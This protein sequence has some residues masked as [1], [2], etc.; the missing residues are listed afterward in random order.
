MEYPART[1]F[2]VIAATLVIPAC[3]PGLAYSLG[4][5]AVNTGI[6]A[7]ASAERRSEGGCWTPCGEGTRCN[8]ETGY[9]ESEESVGEDPAQLASAGEPD[10]AP[11][12]DKREGARWAMEKLI[13]ICGSDDWS[14]AADLVAYRGDDPARRW[15]DV[16]DYSVPDEKQHVDDA[17]SF[18]AGLLQAPGYAGHEFVEFWRDEE[19]EGEWL[20]WVVVFDYGQ[21]TEQVVFASLAI[22]GSYA[23]GDID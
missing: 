14:G 6:A 5:A 13:G 19:S 3:N 23:L 15:K 16:C 17:C 20:V 9:C 22:G 18:I 11:P 4:N 7:G 8:P 12:I 21:E 10:S 2:S 1:I